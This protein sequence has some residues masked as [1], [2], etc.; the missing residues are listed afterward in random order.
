MY[1]D[2]VKKKALSDLFITP[3]SLIPA[4][5]GLTGLIGAWAND[6]PAILVFG[7]LF[8]LAIACGAL[9]TRFTFFY[10]KLLAKAWETI[11][12]NEKQRKHAQ[13]RTLLTKFRFDDDEDAADAMGDLM[14]VY[15][16]FTTDVKESK[17]SLAAKGILVD[18]AEN[19]F[20]ES[21]IQLTSSHEL[22]LKE[23][24]MPLAS[25]KLAKANRERKVKDVTASIKQ[26][27]KVIEQSVELTNNY[28]SDSNVTSLAKE[29]E[30]TLNVQ[31]RTQERLASMGV[32]D[33]VE[34]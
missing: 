25:R 26:L 3:W 21:V 18:Q 28:R 23:R 10:D 8:G 31:R 19:L 27:R 6:G 7:G 14:A 20:S 30:A 15:D 4:G 29:L 5:L 33:K 2:E 16:Q 12:D 22:F 11:R 1:L 17:V 13:L 9:V 32:L 24:E 34:E